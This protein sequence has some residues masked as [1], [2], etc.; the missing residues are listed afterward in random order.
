MLESETWQPGKVIL[1]KVNTIHTYLTTTNYW[2]PLHKAEE[3]DHIEDHNLTKVV[4]SIANANS[5]KWTRW[6]EQQRIMKLIID[7]GAMSNFVPEE[8]NLPKKEKSNK[9]V[10]LPDNTILQASYK[11]KLPFEQLT[12]NVREADI[13]PG[14]RIP[15]VS[16]NKLA[17]EGY[18]TVF[19]PGETGVTIHKLG[20]IMIAMTK[21]PILQGCISKEAKLWTLSTEN[22]TRKEWANNVYNLPSINQTVKY[23]HTAAG[24]PD[25]DT[26][27][28]AIKAE[29]FNTWP[30]I[31]PCMVR[32]HFPESEKAQ[33]G[34]M[35]KQH[36]RV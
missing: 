1:N 2:A 21:P 25:E 20:T 19:H 27:P 7:S 14:C 24:F 36:Q 5:N 10:Y 34:H 13:L 35:K 31:T 6:V 17:K 30:T 12:S 9:E 32:R 33:K 23:L 16:I 3:D 11:T 4:Q 18:T 8:M 29:N 22:K 28:K 26:W 15:L